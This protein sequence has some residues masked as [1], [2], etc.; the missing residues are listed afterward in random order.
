[1]CKTGHMESRTKLE[2]I[3]LYYR[4]EGPTRSTMCHG[5]HGLKSDHVQVLHSRVGEFDDLMV[6]WGGSEE[7]SSRLA[8]CTENSMLI[9]GQFVETQADTMAPPQPLFLLV[10]MADEVHRHGCA[11]RR[12]TLLHFDR[13]VHSFPFH[14]SFLAQIVGH[15][16]AGPRIVRKCCPDQ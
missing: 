13:A 2:R 11:Y 16:R 15:G 12:L 4:P 14:S 8:A 1:M 3:V 7:P 5:D 6:G 10:Q 9:G